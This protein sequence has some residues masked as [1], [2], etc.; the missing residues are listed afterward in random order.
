MLRHGR[1]C[2]PRAWRGRPEPVAVPGPRGRSGLRD[3]E[4]PAGLSRAA[5]CGA[6]LG[7][8]GRPRSLRGAQEDQWRRSRLLLGSWARAAAGQGHSFTLPGRGRTRPRRRRRREGR[9][10]GPGPAAAARCRRRGWPTNS[11]SE[12]PRRAGSRVSHW[13]RNCSVSASS[14]ASDQDAAADQ[15]RGA[16]DR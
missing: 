5:R 16:Y 6:P 10:T 7:P 1:G 9:R 4:Q 13:L 2:A 12:A 8:E 3:Q 11:S 14:A 15:A